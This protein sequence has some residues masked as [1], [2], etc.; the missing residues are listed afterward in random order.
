M[1]KLNM[2]S[3]AEGNFNIS[4][5][6]CPF[7]PGLEVGGIFSPTGFQFDPADFDSEA[8]FRQALI[9]ASYADNPLDRLQTVGPYEDWADTSEGV[10][11]QTFGSGLKRRIRP[12]TLQMDMTLPE[13]RYYHERVKKT[14]DNKHNR[15][16]Y[17]Q[18]LD[19]GD[20]TWIVMGEA[21]RN[22][23]G[24]ATMQGFD[25]NALNISNYMQPTGSTVGL[26]TLQRSFSSPSS[27][28]TNNTIMQVSFNPLTVMRGLQDAELRL[29]STVA[30][31]IHVSGHIEGSGDLKA[32]Y[33]PELADDA[34][35]E[36]TNEVQGTPNVGNDIT[37]LT[38]VEAGD[39]WD[40]T[41]EATATDPDNPGTGGR[42]GVRL[43]APSALGALPVPVEGI[44]S[45]IYYVNLF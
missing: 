44:T 24:V 29:S 37:I 36:V 14:L 3:C 4:K 25:L 42:V 15:Y 20:G 13:D 10:A 23:A 27:V 35:W 38:A 2:L 33:G 39:G 12:A 1:S 9:D 28:D 5:P 40:I 21:A 7:I 34:A 30:N 11:E 8:T 26:F 22:A 43:A 19:Q 17:M 32:L 31:T 41:L 18:V 6:N 45:G 16:D